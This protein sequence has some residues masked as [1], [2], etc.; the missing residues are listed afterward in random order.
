MKIVNTPI[1]ELFLDGIKLSA[2]PAEL[3]EEAPAMHN[4]LRALKSRT[5]LVAASAMY[6]I[7]ERLG[8]PLQYK[9]ALCLRLVGMLSPS[10]HVSR[11]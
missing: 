9:L 4:L 11:P 7:S 1:K 6:L 8:L 2:F 3:G 5:E 10:C